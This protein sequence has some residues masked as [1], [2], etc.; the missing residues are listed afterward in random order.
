MIYNIVYSSRR[1]LCVSVSQENIITVRCPYGTPKAKIERFLNEKAGWIAKITLL[2]DRRNS[3]YAAVKNYSAILVR[4]EILPLTV[5]AKKN[6]ICDT[7]VSVKNI[8]SVQKLFMDNFSSAFLQRV[9]EFCI[10]TSLYPTKISFRNYRSRWGCC[11][12]RNEIIFNYKLFSLP[13]Y[14]A[15]YVIVHELCHILYHN[16]SQNFYNLMAQFYPDW[17]RIRKDL[18]EY[19]FIT[20]LY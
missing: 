19:N 10:K 13:E 17:R 15:D 8:K 11:N 18:Q 9:E 12:G 2:N 7:G 20:N 4:G 6:E 1:N 14:I 5:G 16:H 3:K